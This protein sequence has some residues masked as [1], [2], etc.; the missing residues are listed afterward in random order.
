MRET[1]GSLWS[2]SSSKH[3][4]K[5]L[6]GVKGLQREI[7]LFRNNNLGRIKNKGIEQEQKL[8]KAW[9]DRRKWSGEKWTCA[10]VER[11]EE[12]WG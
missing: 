6:M 12:W 10:G 1:R 2:S 11:R 4:G 5:F 7:V 9:K 3:C 8:T